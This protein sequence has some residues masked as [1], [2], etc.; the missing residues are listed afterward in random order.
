MLIFAL[1]VTARVTVSRTIE[2]SR[3]GD[4]IKKARDLYNGQCALNNSVDNI[5]VAA[6]VAPG[7]DVAVSG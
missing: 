1:I 5:E 4:I 3:G 6:M 7:F 2:R